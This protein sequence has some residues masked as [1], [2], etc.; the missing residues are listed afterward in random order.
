MP[1]TRSKQNTSTSK[2]IFWKGHIQAQ[3]KSGLTIKE[4]CKRHDL[5][6]HTFGYWRKR[7]ESAREGAD[8]ISAIPIARVQCVDSYGL[9]IRTRD[10]HSIEVKGEFSVSDVAGLIKE[11]G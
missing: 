9:R 8:Q 2:Y 11:L 1:G 5:S 7:I 10:G 6:R 4:Y 3:A